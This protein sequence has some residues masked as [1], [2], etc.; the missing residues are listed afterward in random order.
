M[1]YG[2]LR[3]VNAA[4]R[5]AVLAANTLLLL[6]LPA[7]SA[8]AET[9]YVSD[10]LYVPIRTGASS[11]HRIIKVL[12]SGTALELKERNDGWVLVSA[13]DGTD[14]WVE[15]QYVLDQPIAR[16]RLQT[17]T[18]EVERLTRTVAELRENLQGVQ[19]ERR[20][21]EQSSEGLSSEVS[22][23]E[24]ELAEIKSIS[25]GAIETAAANRRLNELNARLRDELDA[26]LAERDRLQANA[27]QRWLMLGGGLVLLGIVLGVVIKSR[28]RRSAWT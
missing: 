3:R 15:E 12:R 11:G 13:E 21:A 24:Q 18:R 14:G 1:G 8:S 26:L 28:P 19:S 4:G 5:F 23:L 6:W 25:A 27:Q 7:G 10:V 9:V 20:E 16:D 22:R 17:A 2:I